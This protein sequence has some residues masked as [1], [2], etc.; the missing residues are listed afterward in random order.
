MTFI[1]SVSG[2]LT[3]KYAVFRGRAG[4][5]EF[6]SFALPYF[7]ASLIFPFIDAKL[8]L[9]V[10]EEYRIGLLY[11]LF[12]LA[13]LS[14]FLA[15]VTRRLHD[16]GRS[17]WWGAAAL[18]FCIVFWK[19]PDRGDSLFWAVSWMSTLLILA[20]LAILLLSWLCMKGTKGRNPYGMD[21]FQEE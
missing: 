14:P 8:G 9:W 19:M 12:G 13:T 17:G 11:A 21:P 3:R 5:R 1:A 18:L 20:I 10:V 16:I 6:W 15:V 4:R 7:L 2:C